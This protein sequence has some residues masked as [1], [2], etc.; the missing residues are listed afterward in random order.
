MPSLDH[1]SPDPVDVEIGARI[2]RYR[3]ARH[4]PLAVVGE[5]AGV[6]FQ[7]IQK[8]EAGLNRIAAA[9]LSR[10]AACLGVS[11]AYLMGESQDAGV[12]PE[13][14]ALLRAPGAFALLEAYAAIRTQGARAALIQLAEAAAAPGSG[15]HQRPAREP[16]L[17]LFEPKSFMAE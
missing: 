2:K 1:P 6:S 10:I 8:Y 17:P 4:L 11:A 5:A 7:Q 14:V 9:T 16:P 12:D 3:Q 15:A 13:T